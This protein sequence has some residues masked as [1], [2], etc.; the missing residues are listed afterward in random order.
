MASNYYKII[1]MPQTIQFKIDPSDQGSRLDKFLAERLEEYSRAAIQKMIKEK[2]ILVSSNE[3]KPSYKLKAGDIIDIKSATDKIE[4][5]PDPSINIE[6]LYDEK[7]FAVI[8]KPAGLVVYPGTK[9]EEKTLVNGLLAKWPEIR[10]VGEDPVRPGIVHRLDKDTSGIMIIAKNNEAFQYFKNLFKNRKIEKIYT[11]LVFGHLAETDGSTLLTTG[12]KI[13]FPI[14]RSKNNPIKQVAVAADKDPEGAREAI[15]YFKVLKYFSDKNE[16]QY[17]FVEAKPKTGR[18]HQI[19]VHLAT[20]GHP[21]VGDNIYQTKQ[22]KQPPEISRQLLHASAIK[23]ISQLGK[24]VEFTSTLPDDF[25]KFLKTL[26]KN[27][28]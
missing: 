24:E 27:K 13:E 25:S 11:A 8:D 3:T 22:N 19:R 18:M 10:F 5:K 7:D 15:T 21:I 14:R 23:F 12:G 6:V 17:T 1:Y 16:N 26:K 2:N 28:E 9:H 4:L 20:L